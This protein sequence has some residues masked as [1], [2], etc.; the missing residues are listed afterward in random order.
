MIPFV[1]SPSSAATASTGDIDSPKF[2]SSPKVGVGVLYN[3]A[4]PDFLRDHLDAVDYL[5]VIPDMFWTDQGQSRPDR[6]LETES[7]IEFLDWA[8]QKLPVIAH[9]IGFSLGSAEIFDEQYLEQIGKWTERYRFPWHSDH[10]SF[11]QVH[12]AGENAH[13][14]GLAMPVP[15]D[16]DVLAMIADRVTRIQK[17]VPIPFLLENNVYYVNIPDQDMTEPEFLNRLTE[18]TGCGLLLDLHNLYANAR[19]HAFDA[20]Q[21]LDELDLSRVVEIH[22]AGGNELAGMYTDSHAGPCPDPVWKLLEQ[23]APLST[24]LCGITFEFHESYYPLL[25]TDGILDHLVRA[26]RTWDAH[27]P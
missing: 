4:L 25:K 7:W 17:A 15:Y 14:A 27:H 26:R 24:N 2:S 6:Y 20:T 23:V 11:V 18:L 1:A 9:D 12:V 8:A 22:I 16:H 10:L 21:F 3:P 5:E 13:N 19:N